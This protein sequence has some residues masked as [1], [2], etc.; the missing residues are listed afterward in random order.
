MSPPSSIPAAKDC[1]YSVA[2]NS[3]TSRPLKAVVKDFLNNLLTSGD[4]LD[5]LKFE[6][7]SK[8]ENALVDPNFDDSWLNSGGHLAFWGA[9]EPF[10]GR[11]QRQYFK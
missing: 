2:V 6:I 10:P 8:D 5:V 7:E 9:K 4:F 3:V 1:I 11:M